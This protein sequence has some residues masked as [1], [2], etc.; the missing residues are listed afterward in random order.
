LRAER[1]LARLVLGG[2]FVVIAG[3]FIAPWTQ[4]VRGMGRVIAYAPSAR[5]TPI[6]API[7]GLVVRWLVVEGEHVK[8]GQVI[9]E[10]ADND[11]DILERLG[12]ARDAVQSKGS[13]LDSAIKIA[14][15][16][17]QALVEARSAAVDNAQQQVAIAVAERD[18]KSQDVRA[19]EAKLN[20]A[21]INLRRQRELNRQDL[22]SDRALELAELAAQTAQ[23]E[24][25][26]KRAA[27]RAA[28]RKTKAAQATL[29]EK[30]TSKQASIEK[31]RGELEKLRGELG[32]TEAKVAD[33][34][35]KLSRQQQMRVVAPRDGTILSVIA[36][37]GTDYLKV[38]DPLAT[39]VPDTDDRAI[40][41]WVDGN[42]APLI[43]KGRKVRIQFEGWPAVQF[44]GWPSVA[45]GTFGGE[46]SF[47]DRAARKDGKFR[48]VVQPDSDDQPWPDPSVL[49]QGVRVKAWVLLNRVTVA[50]ELWRQLNG[51][52]PALPEPQ[53]EKMFK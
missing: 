42:D 43:T 46:V 22:A 31:A 23:S 1:L 27:F 49:R 17:V 9:A 32:E 4:T 52:P 7:K 50:Y 6:K 5:E 16:Q 34:E 10:L 51:F 11:Q 18:A 39:F 26:A 36:R 40:E 14:E 28:S 15:G 53:M 45:V 20:T 3:T 21:E 30:R 38:G 41:V 44:V 29:Q 2:L 25:L 37:E 35:V 47:V 13:A 33:A 19:A 48:A 24:L 8:K 12:R